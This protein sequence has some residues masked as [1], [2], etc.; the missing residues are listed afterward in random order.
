MVLEAQP[1]ETLL[2]IM[3]ESTLS[4]GEAFAIAGLRLGLIVKTVTLPEVRR[5]Y[6]EVPQEVEQTLSTFRPA[7]TLNILDKSAEETPFRVKLIKTETSFGTR[8]GHIPG[9]AMHLLTMGPLALSEDEYRDMQASAQRLQQ[10]LSSASVIRVVTRLGTEVQLS[11]EGREWISDVKITKEHWGNLPC[12]ELFI[13]PLEN[14]LNGVLVVDGAIGDFGVPPKFLYIHVKNGVI[15]RVECADQK[16]LNEVRSH[17]AHD[18]LA[19]RVG[20]FGIGFNPKADPRSPNMLDAEKAAGTV[21]I[22]F[23]NN[24]D[25][26]GQNTSGTHRDFLLLDPTLQADGRTLMRIGKLLL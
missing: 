2:I 7:I 5:P 26:G 8:L 14:S 20:E 23:G 4:V 6:K 15:H 25:F 22:A 12:G 1:G 16:F 19:M 9:A 10:I 13:A 24:T 18:E 11:V 21:H 3:H 17:L